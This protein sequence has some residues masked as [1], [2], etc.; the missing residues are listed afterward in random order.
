MN[1][2]HFQE[3]KKIIMCAI[4]EAIA[5]EI[6]DEDNAESTAEEIL[7]RGYTIVRK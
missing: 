5:G 3:L 1:E 7:R 4:K 6:G 2:A